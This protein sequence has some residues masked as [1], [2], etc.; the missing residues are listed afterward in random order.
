M[1]T[2]KIRVHLPLNSDRTPDVD[3]NGHYDLQV[4]GKLAVSLPHESNSSQIYKKT[5]NNPIISFGTQG[6]S[7]YNEGVYTPEAN[8][9]FCSFSFSASSLSPISEWLTDNECVYTGVKNIASRG[10][11]DTFKATIGDFETYN[12][13]KTSCFAALAEWCARLGYSN[14]LTIYNNCTKPNGGYDANG[15]KK[16]IVWPMFKDYHLD[17]SFDSVPNLSA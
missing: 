13:A 4:K 6:V 15:Y 17:W 10:N 8:L 3:N 11:S 14:L 9:M 7:I 5:Y 2:C 12:P 16:Y 1:A